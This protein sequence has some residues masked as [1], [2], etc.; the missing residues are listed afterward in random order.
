[1]ANLI[2]QETPLQELFSSTLEVNGVR[3][4]VKREDR[5]HPR[6][7]GNKW[8]KL[9]YNLEEAIRQ[10]KTT[11]LT[12]GGAYSNH[13]YATSAAAHELGLQSMGII[14][15]EETG[16]LNS[17]LVFA[18]E[19]GMRLHYVTREA[20]RHKSE[21]AFIENLKFQFG[22]FYLIPEGGT[23]KLAVK[24]CEELAKK[25]IAQADCDYICLPVGTGGTMTGM[26]TGLEGNKEVIGYAALKGGEFLKD[27][28]RNQLIN[29][30]GKVWNNWRIETAYHFGGYG[31]CPGELTDFI[32]GQWKTH[33]LPLDTVYTSKM[34]FGIFDGVKK[35]M[36]RK[37]ATILALHTGGLQ[38]KTEL[39]E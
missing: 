34:M 38:G 5:N 22:E 26:I 14:R 17:T 9:K 6:V 20:Y 4:I 27:D 18:R 16:P 12:F 37:G 33:H 31:K 23:N 32:S 19:Q 1:M 24:G 39:S 25:I 15:G 28:V 11:L 10:N 13:I 35:G 8:W 2:Y 21:A 30:S 3:I 29:Y 36:F 7:S